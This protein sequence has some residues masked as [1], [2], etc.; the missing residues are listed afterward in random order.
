MGSSPAAVPAFLQCHKAVYVSSQHACEDNLTLQRA[1]QTLCNSSVGI[2]PMYACLLEAP[3][4]T[5]LYLVIGPAWR[6]QSKRCLQ[7]TCRHA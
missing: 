5:V 4:L 2:G 6:M 1:M 7:Q 3:I